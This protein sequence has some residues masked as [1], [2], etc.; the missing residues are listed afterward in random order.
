MANPARIPIP[1][2]DD[3]AHT[4][5]ER[6]VPATGTLTAAEEVTAD[7]EVTFDVVHP[8]ASPTG[9]G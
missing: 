6:T 3:A 4:S 8:T 5:G 7:A 1:R 9:R 2:R